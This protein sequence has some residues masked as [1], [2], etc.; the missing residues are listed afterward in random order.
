[1]RPP[2]APATRGVGGLRP[3]APLGGSNFCNY[4]K[5]NV[6]VFVVLLRGNSDAP[7]L[8]PFLKFYFVVLM[9]LKFA[10][11]CPTSQFEET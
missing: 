11:R 9:L 5:T 2:A 7:D 8:W 10:G 6:R 1:M 4:F 3:A